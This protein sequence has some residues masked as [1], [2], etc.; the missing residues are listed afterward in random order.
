MYTASA[1]TSHEAPCLLRSGVETKIDV[2]VICA[3]KKLSVRQTNLDLHSK[4]NVLR[5]NNIG[6][7]LKYAS[8]IGSGCK[9]KVSGFL[10]SRA[11]PTAAFGLR[12]TGRVTPA[13]A[14]R[15]ARLIIVESTRT[16][17]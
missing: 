17:P 10:S 2:T 8:R 5:V 6:L 13:L 3:A 11:P 16:A 4:K 12:R 7:L 15:S 14:V 9:S 1:R